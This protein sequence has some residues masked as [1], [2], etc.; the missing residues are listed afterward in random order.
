LQLESLRTAFIPWLVTMNPIN[1]RPMRRVARWSALPESS[2]PLIDDFVAGRLMVKDKRDGEEVAE[3]ALESLLRQWDDLTEWLAEERENL[4]TADDVERAAAAWESRGR[5]EGWLLAGSR[6]VAADAVAQLPGYRQLLAHAA[7]FLAASR[8]R[9]QQDEAKQH[10]ISAPGFIYVLTG[11]AALSVAIVY[12]LVLPWFVK[13]IDWLGGMGH[14]LILATIAGAGLLERGSGRTSPGA[15]AWGCAF[16]T[17]G[18]AT[19]V[20]SMWHE[21]RTYTSEIAQLLF[22]AGLVL[23]LTPKWR[24]PPYRTMALGYFLAGA[25]VLLLVVLDGASVPIQAFRHVAY[26]D[27]PDVADHQCSL[28]ASQ[29]RLVDD[30]CGMMY[31][32]GA[33]GM[34]AGAGL[35]LIVAGV[36]R[37]LR[38]IKRQP[39][40]H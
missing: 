19:A 20:L 1:D 7:D 36:L 15:T 12:A 23:I 13:G 31:A 30:R 25:A 37:G 26:P 38:A 34:G 39:I 22:F 10:P 11:V 4:K 33:L 17:T 35:V 28:P 5:D 6:L 29:G 27:V 9:A 40:A 21:L 16:V 8:Q 18:A 24:A 2:R 32:Q 3:V 14:L